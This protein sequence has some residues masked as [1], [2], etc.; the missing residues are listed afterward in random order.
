MKRTN[1]V[2]TRLTDEEYTFFASSLS[3]KSG[4]RPMFCG[5]WSLRQGKNARPLQFLR[6]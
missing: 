4:A 6:R 5:V 2:G 3:A 1:M